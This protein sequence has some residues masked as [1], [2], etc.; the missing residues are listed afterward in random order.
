M[1]GLR[2]AVLHP[3]EAQPAPQDPL[4]IK[5]DSVVAGCRQLAD[6]PR[7]PA[8]APGRHARGRPGRERLDRRAR[9][10]RSS[11][12]A[13]RKRSGARSETCRGAVDPGRPRPGRSARI[14][15]SPHPPAV[16]R[17]PRRR[18]R[19]APAGLLPTS[20]WP[21]GAWASARPSARPGPS[22]KSE[23]AALCRARLDS[24]LLHGTTTAEAKSGYG[25][26][27]ADEIK[28]L[29]AL[30]EAGREPSRR[31]RPDLHG[32]PRGARRIP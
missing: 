4:M 29:E 12:S 21:P 5:A 7:S 6:L 23:L 8:Q 14:R 16:R 11:S 28:Q 18:V 31:R 9:G 24:M 10:A 20:S 3:P 1:G 2:Q 30:A 25:L 19:P 15:R 13:A 22:P 32:R 17:Q 27:L 26:N